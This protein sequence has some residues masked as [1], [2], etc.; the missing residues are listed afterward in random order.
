[1]ATLPEDHAIP[2]HI[3]FD[4]PE[5]IALDDRLHFSIFCFGNEETVWDLGTVERSCQELFDLQGRREGEI[6]AIWYY[7]T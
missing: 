5:N 7:S 2:V 3:L 4:V 1:M 6:C